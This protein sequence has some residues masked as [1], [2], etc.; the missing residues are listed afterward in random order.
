MDD[1]IPIEKGKRRRRRSGDENAGER[2]VIN[3]EAAL[4]DEVNDYAEGL[5][6]KLGFKPTFQQALLYI[7]HELR[8]MK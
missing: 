7:M 4:V 8:K 2:K 6:D 1:G 5:E 3:V